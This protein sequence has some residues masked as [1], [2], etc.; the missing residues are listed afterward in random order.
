M[1]VQRINK[2]ILAALLLLLGYI[3]GF[4][5]SDCSTAS[6]VLEYRIMGFDHFAEA[7]ELE[8]ELNR[9]GAQGW[10]LIEFGKYM[11]VFKR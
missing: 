8:D 2:I 10:E 9:M 1:R 5:S 11:A 7:E 3:V 6:N 4:V